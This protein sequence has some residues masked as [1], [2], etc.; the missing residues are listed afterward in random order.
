[1][2]GIFLLAN[3]IFFAL[4]VFKDL[5]NTFQENP[6][7]ILPKHVKFSILYKLFS[8]LYL[9]FMP[10][11]IHT[12]SGINYSYII[13]YFPSEAFSFS[14]TQITISIPSLKIFAEE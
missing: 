9:Q 13:Y 10:S 7:K 4:H 14:S 11:A 2:F 6:K 8:L 1:M 12:N 5:S 3:I